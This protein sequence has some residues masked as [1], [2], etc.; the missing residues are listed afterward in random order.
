MDRVTALLRRLTPE[1]RAAARSELEDH[2]EDHMAALL[3]LGYDEALAE[4]RT[5]ATMGD[6]EEV[7][8]ALDA[9]Y[10]LG[11]LVVGRIALV[12]TVVVCI[13]AALGFGILFNAVDSVTARISPRERNCDMKVIL[14]ES[15]VDIRVPVGDDTLRV[16]Q[17]WVGKE[18][19]REEG[20]LQAEVAL[21]VYDR[22]PFGIASQRAAAD[23]VLRDQRGVET[24]TWRAGSGGSYGAVYA[25]R[26]VEI[27]P[28][29]TSVTL[30]CDQF[31]R[32]TAVE[33]PLPEKEGTP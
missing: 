3:E 31:G 10:P 4:E 25:T 12:L 14:A 29:D 9:Q 27:Q 16:Y 22:I 8:R 28:G 7:G 26:Q 30:V 21:C 20:P 23:A 19:L 11:W 13:Q 17:V 5:M 2:I 33:I 1:E 32:H 18:S 24:E 6:P 15:Q